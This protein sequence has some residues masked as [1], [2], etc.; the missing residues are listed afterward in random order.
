MERYFGAEHGLALT[1]A[2]GEALMQTVI[3]SARTLALYPHDYKARA[4]VMWA[5]SLSHN[6]LTGCGAVGDWACHQIEHELGGMFDVAHG[7]GLAAVWGSW[8]RYV[9]R[10]DLARFAQFAYRVMGVA[11]A[12]STEETAL[13]GISAFED[14]LRYIGMPTTIHDLGVDLTDE[15]IAVLAHKCTF[16]GQRT[17]GTFQVLQ[18]ADIAA[19][20]RA[21]R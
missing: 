17:I 15:Q 3:A 18:E 7:A 21:A 5:S 12:E 16:Q 2:M 14:F 19:I 20:Y 9:Y 10:A 4:N 8:A 13:R 1:D 6:G 11:A